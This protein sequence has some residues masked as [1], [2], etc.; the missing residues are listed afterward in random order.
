M[1]LGDLEKLVLQYLWRVDQADAKQVHKAIESERKNTLNTVQSALERLH[2]KQLLMRTKCGHAYQY[3]AN[4]K[5]EELIAQLITNVTGDFV[6]DGEHGLIAAF[7]STSDSLNDAELDQ[8]SAI[9][10][11][12]RRQRQS[13]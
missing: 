7:S 9:I 8:L 5:R 13:K 12:Q 2:K 10:E 4:V 3:S 11:H 6:M 1:Q